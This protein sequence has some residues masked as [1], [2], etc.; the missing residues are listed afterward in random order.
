MKSLP[1]INLAAFFF[2]FPISAYMS[3][4]SVEFVPAKRILQNLE[5]QIAKSPSD[6][7]LRV[8]YARTLSLA[9]AQQASATNADARIRVPAERSAYSKEQIHVQAMRSFEN[10][11]EAT[12]ST[13]NPTSKTYLTN[14]IEQYKRAML[15]G[16]TNILAYLG[17]GWCLKEDRQTN[18]A[19]E[20]LRKA[21]ELSK[22]FR[23]ALPPGGPGMRY[24]SDLDVTGEICE[25]LIALLDPSKD[26]AEIAAVAQIKARL[27]RQSGYVT[28][29]L[30]PLSDDP[31][32]EHYVNRNASVPFDL[33]GMDSRKRWQWI[34]KNAAWLVYCSDTKAQK[35]TS[36]RQM[37]GNVTFFLFWSDGF[38]ALRVL[39]DDHNGVL[40]GSELDHLCLWQDANSNG[41]SDPGEVVTLKESNITA[42]GLTNIRSEHEAL[43]CREGARFGNSWR[44]TFDIMLKPN[45]GWSLAKA[46]R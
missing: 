2:A 23:Q 14:A 37:F 36:G 7:G 31:N 32:P 46:L 10:R 1:A 43:I 16:Q 5:A 24:H 17:Q 34:R 18:A 42:L 45:Q 27:R 28:P 26:A 20:S 41:A 35:I 8:Q 22:A 6:G 4:H 11:K 19:I 3:P 12:N 39:D 33:N 30:V 9:Y 29:I 44:P 15:L 25:Y 13:S 40:D 21:F 38:A